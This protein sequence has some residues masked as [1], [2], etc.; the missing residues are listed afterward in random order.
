MYLQKP[1]DLYF[2][3]FDLKAFHW[4]E[5]KSTLPFTGNAYTAFIEEPKEE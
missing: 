5:K 4:T 1:T 2:D 3:I